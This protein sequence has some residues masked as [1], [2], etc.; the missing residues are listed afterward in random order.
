M[1]ED[2]TGCLQSLMPL[3]DWLK[4]ID[5][6]AAIGRQADL[7]ELDRGKHVLGVNRSLEAR[8]RFLGRSSLLNC[9]FDNLS[10]REDEEANFCE[11][12][13]YLVVPYACIA[14]SIL[15]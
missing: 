6:T 11:A 3:T 14:S 9:D 13:D 2:Y 5:G 15:Q 1:H 8:H 7:E 4:D 10:E 12:I